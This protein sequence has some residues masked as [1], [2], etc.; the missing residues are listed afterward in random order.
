M[1]KLIL[2]LLLLILAVS[3]STKDTFANQIINNR[4]E[5][6]DILRY[7]KAVFSIDI[8][9]DYDNP[10]IQEQVRLDMVLTTPGGETRTLPCFYDDHADPSPVWKAHFAPREVGEYEYQFVLHVS[11]EETDITPPQSFD[12]SESGRS[13]FITKHPDPDEEWYVPHDSGDPFRGIG[14]NMGWESRS[15]EDPQHN[16]DYFFEKLG[17]HG[18]NFVR[19]WMHAWNLPLEWQQVTQTNR[20]SNTD[21]Y[22]HPG[23]I[24]RMDEMIALAEEHGIYIMLALDAHGGFISDGEWPLNSYNSANGG[25]VD[26]PEEFF[27]SDEAKAKYKNR[28]RY[29]VGRWGYSTAI[30]VWEFFNE[31]DNIRN[32]EGIPDFHITQWHQEMSTYLKS[33]DPYDHLVSTSISHDEIR[34]LFSVGNLDINQEHFYRQTHN[35]PDALNNH[36]TGKPFVIGE[37]GREW[38]WNLDFSRI[39]DEKIYDFKRGLWYGLFNPTPILPM[40]W[41]WEWFDDRDLLEYFEGVRLI[42]DMMLDAGEGRFEHLESSFGEESHAV[43]ADSTIFIYLLNDS[44]AT[45]R[46][47]AVSVLPGDD[48]VY[49]TSLF[50][51]ETLEFTDLGE[52]QSVN[53]RVSFSGVDLE[54]WGQKVVILDPAQTETDPDPDTPAGSFELKG[55]YPNPFHNQTRIRFAIHE[56]R[57]LNMT[58]EIYD[59]LGRKVASLESRKYLSQGD[60]SVDFHAEEQPAG[61]Y[62]YRLTDSD[63]EEVGKMMLIN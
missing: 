28:L 47:R 19:T 52:Q 12:V 61:L 40:S 25:P 49:D 33:I 11:G 43:K 23:A 15:W 1:K 27:T 29:L 20:Y 3:A 53:G 18:A 62:I 9:A 6:S 56:P 8:D 41:W 17:A 16:Y 36:G 13:G 63:S 24:K 58:L 26:T 37:F 59:V 42:S 14:I 31:V 22:F 10:Y 4:L 21:K 34:G 7:E 2:P 60:H 48:R 35:I 51:P 44:Q 55:N 50:D 57:G 32:A 38:D 30:G 46:D 54:P 39:A 5:N 45:M